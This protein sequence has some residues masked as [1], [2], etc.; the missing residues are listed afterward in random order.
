MPECVPPLCLPSQKP[1]PHLV[2]YLVFLRNNPLQTKR[3]A[4]AWQV[5][6]RRFEKT[7]RKRR[8]FQV[9]GFSQKRFYLSWN[10]NLEP[11]RTGSTILKTYGT[12]IYQRLLILSP[13][14]MTLS[15]HPCDIC[16]EQLLY[17][18]MEKVWQLQHQISR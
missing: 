18:G 4:Q 13:S 3:I 5:L 16:G 2:E 14:S 8:W 6:L 7:P 9:T 17:I 12:L 1:S 15:E 10:G 11:L